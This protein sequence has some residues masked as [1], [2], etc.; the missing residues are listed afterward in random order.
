MLL[1]A[2]ASHDDHE[3]QATND[4]D[5]DQQCPVLSCWRPQDLPVWPGHYCNSVMQKF[6]YEIGIIQSFI[7]PYLRHNGQH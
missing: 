4:E 6:M 5:L 3:G 7:A 1:L 2:K